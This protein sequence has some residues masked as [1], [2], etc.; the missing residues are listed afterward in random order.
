M[1][2]RRVRAA[3]MSALTIYTCGAIAG[4]QVDSPTATGVGPKL[5]I[6]QTD[7]D[8]GEVWQGAPVTIDV[9]LKNVGDQP[10]TIDV[11][12]SCGCT[13]PT[14]PKSPLPPGEQDVMKIKYDATHRRGPTNQTV[15]IMTNDPSHANVPFR[16]TGTVKPAYELAP[17]DSLAFGRIYQDTQ[18][19]KVVELTNLHPDPMALRIKDGQNFGPFDLRVE[20]REPGRKFA[21]SAATKNPMPVGTSRVELVLETGLAELKEITVS[22][23]ATVQAPIVVHPSRLFLPRNSVAPLKHT[24]RVQHAPGQAIRVVEVRTSVPEIT[25]EIQETPKSDP[26]GPQQLIQVTLPPG[27]AVPDIGELAVELITDSADPAFAKLVVPVRVVGS[28]AN[29]ATRPVDSGSANPVATQPA[30]R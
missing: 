10:L 6:S 19:T 14:R 29:P 24:L 17:V 21:I 15:T 23:Y 1:S 8:F 13:A 7:W 2:F 4:A 12:T 26:V 28:V 18:S 3:A 16:V 25:A 9:T 11:R 22:V 27:S 20:P 30:P 5:E